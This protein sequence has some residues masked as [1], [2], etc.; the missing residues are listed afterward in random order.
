MY[1]VVVLLLSLTLSHT[2]S[3]LFSH[4]FFVSHSQTF[5]GPSRKHHEMTIDNAMHG[6]GIKIIEHHHIKQYYASSVSRA[7][8]SFFAKSPTKGP[9]PSALASISFHIPQSFPSFSTF[10]P[11]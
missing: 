1:K 3:E 5:H 2:F 7:T 6:I 9:L 4:Q 8:S 10:F 11:A